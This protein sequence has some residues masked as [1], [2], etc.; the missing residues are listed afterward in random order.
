[1]SSDRISS[2]A[3]RCKSGHFQLNIHR[4]S[5]DSEVTIALPDGEIK[6]VGTELTVWIDGTRTSQIS[7]ERGN[8]IVRMVGLPEL[9]PGAGEH[10]ERAAEARAEV[11]AAPEPGAPPIEEHPSAAPKK[12][13]EQ[14]ASSRPIRL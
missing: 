6:D 8:V 10:W 13:F 11:P 7:V 5:P 4:L 3:S 9:R 1:V 14:R 2:I 12:Q